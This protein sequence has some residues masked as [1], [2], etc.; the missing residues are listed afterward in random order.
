MSCRLN[1]R[2]WGVCLTLCLALLSSA[3]RTFADSIIQD[4]REEEPDSSFFYIPYAFY[5]VANGAAVG[6]WASKADKK[7]KQMSLGGTFFVSQ[8]GAAL[9]GLIGEGLRHPRIPRLFMNG[10]AVTS[11]WREQ[12]AYISNNPH[13]SN[14]QA[15]SNSSSRNNFIEGDGFD[16]TFEAE[17]HYLLPLGDGKGN[18]VNTYVLDRGLLVSGA[19]GGRRW[20]P[21]TT[22]RTD[23]GIKPFYQTR[24]LG[25]LFTDKQTSG[26]ELHLKHDNRDFPLNPS[27]GNFQQLRMVRDFGLAHN[28]ETWTFIDATAEQFFSLGESRK[29]RQ[30]VLA[31]SAW[32]GD[33][34]TARRTATSRGTRLA[35]SAPYY[36]GAH[37]GGVRRLRGFQTGRFHGASSVY[38][39]AEM[40]LVPQ[41]TPWLSQHDGL[42]TLNISWWQ[43]V[44]FV[45]L[46]RVANSWNPEK[47]HSHMK[48]S[49]GLSLR[50]M[51]KKA[52]VRGDIAVSG[53][54]VN[55]WVYV[56]HPFAK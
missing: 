19:T 49:T 11:Y 21:L 34:P 47:L 54:T 7:E 26:A 10:K 38:Y 39:S 8:K 53:E 46:G 6:I 44:P 45:E 42:R 27:K 56:G 29:F 33:T 5:T 40:R 52:L 3:P 4:H 51:V 15:G 35:H 2:R 9:L 55:L 12:R 36:R 14:Q 30:R 1:S 37:L 48:F 18:P 23:I 50:S 16:N 25:R 24:D 43:I 41:G 20:N 17:F 13:F 31:L 32:T 22:G 28:S